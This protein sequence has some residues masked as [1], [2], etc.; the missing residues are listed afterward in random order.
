MK[1]IRPALNPKNKPGYPSNMGFTIQPIAV[2]AA[3]EPDCSGDWLRLPKPR[4][5]LWGMSR[6]TWN[7]LLDSGKVH[8][9]DIRK[10][11][12]Q[13]GIKLIYRPSAEAYLKGLLP[14]NGTGAKS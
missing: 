8:H 2:P 13:R 10:P 4:Q 11:H 12:A 3:N 7:E 14:D 9:I 5:R 1:L 6:T